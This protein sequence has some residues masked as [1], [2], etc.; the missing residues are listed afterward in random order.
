MRWRRGLPA[1]S[2]VDEVRDGVKVQLVAPLAATHNQVHPCQFSRRAQRVV[3]TRPGLG[4]HGVMT[5][6]TPRH[7]TTTA[8][9]TAP[10]AP[11]QQHQ[12]H[13]R[14]QPHLMILSFWRRLSSLRR[15]LR[16]L[17]PGAGLGAP[18]PPTEGSADGGGSMDTALEPRPARPPTS[19][20]PWSLKGCSTD[21]DMAAG[22]PGGHLGPSSGLSYPW[23][24]RT[25]S[26]GEATLCGQQE[27]ARGIAECGESD[28]V[29]E[30]TTLR[31]RHARF[32][33][34]VRRCLGHAR[35]MSQP[36]HFTSPQKGG[37]QVQVELPSELASST[38]VARTL[39]RTSPKFIPLPCTTSCWGW[40]ALQL[41]GRHMPHAG[42]DH[43]LRPGHRIKVAEARH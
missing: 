10:P 16:P 29:C 32:L 18:V 4:G 34:G 33:Q 2:L 25:H 7:A 37:P 5:C 43:S 9:A 20:E 6:A 24:C 38:H 17:P 19:M 39:S 11:M 8:T 13:P 35:D 1:D 14:Q 42:T 23:W 41:K 27:R 30:V 28:E 21:T 26:A 40:Q 36:C 31:W 12:H 3:F 22:R 15:S